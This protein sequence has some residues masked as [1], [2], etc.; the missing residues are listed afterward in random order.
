MKNPI[1]LRPD[2]GAATNTPSKLQRSFARAVVAMARAGDGSGDAPDIVR[3]L[4]RGD[5]HALAMVEKA[6]VVPAS[7]S[8]VTTFNETVASNVISLLAPSSATAA[9][10]SRALGVSLDNVYGVMIPTVTASGSGVSFIAQ[11]APIP[12]KQFSFTGPTLT[13]QK[14]GLI[15]G[16]T[17]ELMIH[18]NADLLV[19]ALLAENLSLGLDTILLDTTAGDTTRPPG[20]RN[21]VS[22]TTAV[23]GGGIAAMVGDLA[24]IASIVAPLAGD[25]I[26]FVASPKQAVKINLYRTSALPYPVI[27]S[28]GLADGVVVAIA[29]NVLAVA[30]GD[31][32]PRI[33][34]SDETTLMFDDST[35]LALGTVGTPNTVAA[36][37]RSLLQQDLVALRLTADITWAMRASGGVAWTQSVTW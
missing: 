30:G 12:V 25:Q 10:F 15:V 20:L 33:Q 27:A 3:Q 2:Y 4:Y 14:V 36:P 23:T 32:P 17:R 11:G 26:I 1:P 16:F 21:G 29:T 9:I 24:N 31:D 7:T 5:H 34:V 28:S 6:A 37:T 18:S 13:S 8:G 19:R 22:A 35:P